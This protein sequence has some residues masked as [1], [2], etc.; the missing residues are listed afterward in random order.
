[1]SNNTD[2]QE[3]QTELS[4]ATTTNVNRVKAALASEPDSEA[5][6]DF[7]DV[8]EE[9]Y[10][11][12]EE[13][14]FATPEGIKASIGGQTVIDTTTTEDDLSAFD[15]NNF[16]ATAQTIV[17]NMPAK[18][19][20]YIALRKPA[21]TEYVRVTSDKKYRMSPVYLMDVKKGGKTVQ[22]L[23]HGKCVGD[24]L[25]LVGSRVVKDYSISLV[26]NNTGDPFLWFVREGAEDPWSE[27]SV[28]LQKR[29][30]NEWLRIQGNG[31]FYVGISPQDKLADPKWPTESF[32]QLLKLA[33]G[34]RIIDSTNH[35]AVKA[36]LGVN[37]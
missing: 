22:Y 9:H 35:P 16:I 5:E 24:V 36:I 3:G 17:A 6:G 27:S 32:P 37:S 28:V 23:V 26:I 29:A 7:N 1:M 19:V 25:S 4:A 12:D 18:K 10:G 8:V 11:A 34:N 31:N 14:E 13:N 30:I 20:D 15:P 2:T 33:F 21:P